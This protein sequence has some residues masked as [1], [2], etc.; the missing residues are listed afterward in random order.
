[1]IEL[2]NVSLEY[3]SR[4]GFRQFSVIRALDNVSL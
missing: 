3:V 2:R 4:T 1:L